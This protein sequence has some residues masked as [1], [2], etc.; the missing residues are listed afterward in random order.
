MTATMSG[1]KAYGF[2]VGKE[3]L[4]HPLPYAH[5]EYGA[6]FGKTFRIIS[7][8]RCDNG[9][10]VYDMQISIA[11]SVGGAG[12]GA[13][14]MVLRSVAEGHL[15]HSDI[16]V[17]ASIDCVRRMTL[18]D[19]LQSARQLVVPLF[20][21]KYCW[22]ET[23]WQGVW[24][25]AAHAGAGH[26]MGRITLYEE[27]WDEHGGAAKTRICDPALRR[28]RSLVIV[29]GQQRTTTLTLYLAAL[30]DVLGARLVEVDPADQAAMK[31]TIE[32]VDG[33]LLPHG[34]QVLVPTEDDR[35]PYAQ[36]VARKHGGPAEVAGASK[37]AGCYRYFAALAQRQATQG[38]LGLCARLA[39]ALSQVWLLYFELDDGVAVARF[40]E[41][42]HV[43]EMMISQFCHVEAPGVGLAEYDL[44]R[45]YLLGHFKATADQVDVYHTLWL[46]I[47]RA[48]NAEDGDMQCLSSCL[49]SFH[50]ERCAKKR[51]LVSAEPP[52]GGN[53]ATSLYKQY[54]ELVIDVL[55][56]APEDAGAEDTV[57]ALLTDLHAHVQ[58][59]A[60][61][62]PP[63][64][65]PAAHADARSAA[66]LRN[67]LPPPTTTAPRPV[68]SKRNL[69][70]PVSRM[71]PQ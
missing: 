10:A 49:R 53:K 65:A 54:Q 14:P 55:K 51:R 15:Q 41:Q 4:L 8:R 33:L 29:D 57:R 9:E 62:V 66:A 13:A 3:V 52:A 31:E 17:K 36:C 23:Q 7:R 60:K 68:I 61:D 42:L 38:L 20:Q 18:Q 19:F 16:L 40:F 71:I 6:F 34:V 28:Q 21:R 35:A 5:A 32:R 50:T 26:S 64:P 58:A 2:E 37:I 67:R 27:V 45:N 63:A 70:P 44:L 56:A 11:T 69:P 30:R 25:D 39:A 43:R 59:H 47:E 1:E 48:A 46:P 12:V 24:R 22:G